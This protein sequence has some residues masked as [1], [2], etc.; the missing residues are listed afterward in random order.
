LS[1][2]HSLNWLGGVPN[3]VGAVA[4]FWR[5]NKSNR[6]IAL[7]G[8]K[9]IGTLTFSSPQSYTISPGTGGTLEF[10][11][12]NGPATLTSIQGVHTV[13]AGVDI[14]SNLNVAIN[15]GT[16]TIS[17]V[18]SGPGD[19]MKTGAGTLALTRAN[20]YTGDTIVQAGTVRIYQPSLADASDVYL[21]TG[22]QLNLAF[23]SGADVIGSLFIDGVSQPTG[24][25]GAVGSS[26]QFTTPLITGGGRLHVSIF[27]GPPLA[28]DFNGD[29]VVDSADYIVWRKG[30]DRTHAEADYGLWRAN[31]GRSAGNGASSNIATAVPEPLPLVLL[32]SV[33]P[34]L[35]QRQSR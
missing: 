12:S 29:G 19:V 3:D 17:G 18:V 10:R 5:T 30:L 2:N 15:A 26:A 20:G 34:L 28:G 8:N 4:N 21:T 24:I 13:I 6:T 23:A 25:W 11:T 35:R 14:A 7:D 1:W 22:A 33:V 16:L 32:V 27:V 9:T 31:F